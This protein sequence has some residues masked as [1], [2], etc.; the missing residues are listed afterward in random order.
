MAFIV[1][2]NNLP[3]KANSNWLATVFQRFR[4]V[5]DVFIPE[6]KSRWGKR[7]GFVRFETIWEAKRAIWNLNGVFFLENKIGVNMARFTPRSMFWK[8]VVRN[9][10]SFVSK[11]TVGKYEGM[12][13]Q[14]ADQIG[15]DKHKSYLQVL[16][17]TKNTATKV[18]N[19]RVALD[20]YK[21]KGVCTGKV[22]N[23]N[24]LWLQRSLISYYKGFADEET[25]KN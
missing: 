10:E 1:F 5:L 15:N 20:E 23:E 12:R 8:K 2:V 16:M 9:R 3:N 11:L 24:L 13:T 18:V 14:R 19:Q 6:K 17:N 7:F 21:D 25:I 4:K 22:D